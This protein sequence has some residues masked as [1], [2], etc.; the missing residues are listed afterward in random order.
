MFYVGQRMMKYFGSDVFRFF[1]AVYADRHIGVH[2]INIALVEFCKMRRIALGRLD[3]ET[4]VRLFIQGLQP[5][6]RITKPTVE[7][8]KRLRAK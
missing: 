1:P 4:L 5:V 6:L 8:E 7:E 3:Q 2:L